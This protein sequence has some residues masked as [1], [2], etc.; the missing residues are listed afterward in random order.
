[1]ADIN[2]VAMGFTGG[3]TGSAIWSH[4]DV[5]NATE[6]ALLHTGTGN[7]FINSALGQDINFRS[8]NV[9]NAR[10]SSAGALEI[11]DPYGASGALNTLS[12]NSKD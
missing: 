1:M 3:Y 4:K 10:I 9:Q 6:Y 5:F 11:G 7:L 8:G 2:K 12:K